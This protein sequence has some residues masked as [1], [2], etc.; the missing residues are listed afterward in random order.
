M[1]FID[2]CHWSSFHD[3]LIFHNRVNRCETT[4]LTF[5]SYKSRNWELLSSYWMTFL[6]YS[7][8]FRSRSWLEPNPYQIGRAA[9]A[10]FFDFFLTVVY[11]PHNCSLTVFRLLQ[12]A[13]DSLIFWLLYD[14]SCS[15]NTVILQSNLIGSQNA[16]NSVFW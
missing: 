2:R 13:C 7:K 9:A 14:C 15:H 4:N 10:L 16:V 1:P 11:L 5:I 6:Q 3:T 8:Y 12:F